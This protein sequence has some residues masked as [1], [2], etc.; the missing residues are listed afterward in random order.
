MFTHRPLSGGGGGGAG[1]RGGIVRAVNA[2][3]VEDDH[4]S[5]NPLGV[6]L[7]PAWWLR[8][9]DPSRL[10]RNLAF[11]REC[12]MDY[13]RILC[14]VGGASWQ[15][16]TVDPR[17]SDYV[18]ILRDVVDEAWDVHHLRTELT[19]FGGGT[20]AD[21]SMV[22]DKVLQAV[23]GRH[24]K[25]MNG[26]GVNENNM[27]MAAMKPIVERYVSSLLPVPVAYAST[28]NPSI[29]DQLKV[30][31]CYTVHLDRT[32]GEMQGEGAP[33][34]ERAIR[35]AWDVK[36]YRK[37]GFHNEP[38]GP[39]SS[40][41]ETSDPRI[42]AMLRWNGII[43]GC[44]GFVFHTGGGIRCGGAADVAR[45]RSA[46]LY[47]VPRFA[48]I[49]DALRA[50]DG[51]VPV[52]A[53]TWR[54]FNLNWAGAP[55]SVDSIWADQSKQQGCNR[56]YSSDGGSAV[57]STVVGVRQHVTLTALRPLGNVVVYDPATGRSLISQRCN[58]GDAIRIEGTSPGYVVVAT[59]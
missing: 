55:W 44:V 20:G 8:K 22:L 21:P 53:S 23:D 50:L 57:V 16:R 10:T 32:L 4:G 39:Q 11:A 17:A 48:E 19:L 25:V 28:D 35:Q 2:V 29:A 30:A 42:L 9:N 24:H 1:A 13:Q 31:T 7:F 18:S 58:A 54:K 52:A 40:V 26:E 36:E 37:P 59:A 5:F 45:G 33:L 56:L 51:V 14:E 34:G 43:C 12:G 3:M 38:I 49:A 46:N 47:D 15:D 6:T 27:D 41:Q